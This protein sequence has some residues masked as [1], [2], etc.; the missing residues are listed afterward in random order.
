MLSKL[1]LE[2]RLEGTFQ[3]LYSYFSMSFERQLEF[4]KLGKIMEIKGNKVLKN[5][6]MLSPLKRFMEEYC[7]LLVKNGI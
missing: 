1:P 3:T 5:V 7:T 2:S 6:H 4:K